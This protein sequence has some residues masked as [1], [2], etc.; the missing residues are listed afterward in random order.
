MASAPAGDGGTQSEAAAQELARLEGQLVQLLAQAEE[1]FH[2]VA[3]SEFLY[4]PHE[5]DVRGA[6]CVPLVGDMHHLNIQVAKL[7][8]YS[9]ER[10]KGLKYIEPLAQ[11]VLDDVE[12]AVRL[13][14]FFTDRPGGARAA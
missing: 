10:A 5:D 9:I 3:V 14:R 1:R 13:T 4:W 12:D 11:D 2:C 7:Q 6:L 8:I